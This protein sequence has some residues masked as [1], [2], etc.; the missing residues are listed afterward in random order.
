M[1]GKSDS[2]NSGKLT[3]ADAALVVS[4]LKIKLGR[5]DYMTL[6]EAGIVSPADM[7]NF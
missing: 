6:D 4:F 1:T 3:V 7:G 2:R 5:S